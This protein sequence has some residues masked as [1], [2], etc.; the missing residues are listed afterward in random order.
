MRKACV[1]TAFTACP[2]SMSPTACR[3]S[4]LQSNLRVLVVP[5]DEELMIARHTLPLLRSR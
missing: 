2:T 5:T 1:A 4:T 3:R